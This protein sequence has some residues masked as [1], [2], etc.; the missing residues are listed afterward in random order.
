MM[1]SGY[2]INITAGHMT[3][4]Q[5]PLKEG[6]YFKSDDRVSVYY[7]I[8]CCFDNSLE[9]LQE[10]EGSGIRVRGKVRVREL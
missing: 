7:Q 8:V 5:P 6:G 3:V 10:T 9:A 1:Y 4:Y 2:T